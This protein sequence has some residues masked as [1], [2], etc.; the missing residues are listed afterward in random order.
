MS[1]SSDPPAGAI[2]IIRNTAITSGSCAL[3]MGDN[4]IWADV[5]GS[6]RI[7]TQNPATDRAG[8]IVGQQTLNAS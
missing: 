6:L 1:I 7:S 5:S 8:R 4:Y 2:K 3:K